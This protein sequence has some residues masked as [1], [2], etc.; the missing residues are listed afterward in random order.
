VFNEIAS[1]I[2]PFILATCTPPGEGKGVRL[3]MIF[4][5]KNWA[6]LSGTN[7]L[8]ID[9][10]NIEQIKRIIDK[11]EERINTAIINP[12]DIYPKD[13]IK[14]INKYLISV[15]NGASPPEKEIKCA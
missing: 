4:I 11:A 14:Y 5:G 15:K 7:N 13:C 1:V 10:T 8:I 3:E 6:K 9:S 2:T 12:R